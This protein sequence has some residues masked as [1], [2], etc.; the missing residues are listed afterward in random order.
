MRIADRKDRLKVGATAR[1]DATALSEIGAAIRAL[2]ETNRAIWRI[3][4]D[5]GFPV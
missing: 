4:V 5:R 1:I 3:V 2:E